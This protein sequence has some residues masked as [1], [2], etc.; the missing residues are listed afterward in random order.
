MPP[1]HSRYLR[2]INYTIRSSEQNTHHPQIVAT[3][4][5]RSDTGD[6]YCQTILH[7]LSNQQYKK[8][9][10]YLN[11]QFS[12]VLKVGFNNWSQ[13]TG[14]LG[15]VVKVAGEGMKEFENVNV[16]EPHRTRVY[17]HF[18]RRP[19]ALLA[20][21]GSVALSRTHRSRHRLHG[22][23]AALCNLKFF[24]LIVIPPS[25]PPHH[26]RTRLPLTSA[27]SS[28]YHKPSKQHPKTVYLRPLASI[29][30]W[31]RIKRQLIGLLGSKLD[32]Y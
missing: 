13:A 14:P 12:G 26:S 22:V 29:F 16:F 15:F 24:V 10:R 1:S 27:N 3:A 18:S 5:T 21:L 20:L 32:G 2:I 11:R 6:Y 28:S 30:G 19:H 8:I 25:T 31:C 17:C 7:H 4:S 23:V 9:R